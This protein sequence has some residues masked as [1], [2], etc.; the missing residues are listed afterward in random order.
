M[1]IAVY[2]GARPLGRELP[3]LRDVPQSSA[4]HLIYSFARDA[5]K[6]GNFAFYDAW[7]LEH[8]VAQQCGN[9]RGML[10]LGG[11]GFSWGPAVGL[12][13]WVGNASH[14][15]QLML[16]RFQLIGLDINIEEGLDEARG[17]PEAMAALIAFLKAWRPSLLITISPFDDTWRHYKPLLQLAGDSIGFINYQLYAELESPDTTAQQAVAVYERLAAEVGG[18]GKLTLGVNT[19]PDEKRG[20]QLDACLAAFRVLK[21]RGIGGA[22]VWALENSCGCGYAAE[23]ALLRI[24]AEQQTT[25]PHTLPLQHPLTQQHHTQQ[26]HQQQQKAQQQQQESQQLVSGSGA[27]CCCVS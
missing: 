5:S 24:A 6:D 14:S 21:A 9:Q 17:F 22:F 25:A 10:S 8:A 27:C 15:L 1:F 2:A 20:P 19:E 7:Q 12:D 11:A 16:D 26:A 3:P 4:L 23:A 18:Y 13:E